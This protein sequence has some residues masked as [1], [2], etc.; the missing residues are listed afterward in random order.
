MP[1]ILQ[2]IISSGSLRF[3]S[4]TMP[5]SLRHLSIKSGDSTSDKAL[6]C[7]GVKQQVSENHNLKA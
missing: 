4:V 6:K 2:T 3:L 5:D 1:T 7:S